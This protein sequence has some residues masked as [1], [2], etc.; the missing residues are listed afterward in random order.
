MGISGFVCILYH[1]GYRIKS[2]I[3]TYNITMYV[4]NFLKRNNGYVTFSL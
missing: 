2:G 3:I 4:N 1:T